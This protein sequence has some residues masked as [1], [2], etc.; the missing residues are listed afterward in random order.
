MILIFSEQQD[1]STN[2]VIDWLHFKDYDFCR[3][4]MDDITNNSNFS[5]DNLLDKKG[6][7][8]KGINIDLISV[9]WFRRW[10]VLEKTYSKL[11]S[12]EPTI[13]E[14]IS[15]ELRIIFGYIFYKLNHAK[16]LTN[17]NQINVNKIVSLDLAHQVG[18]STPLTLITNNTKT[19]LRFKN[20][21]NSIITKSIS[22]NANYICN[23]V[24][25]T[26]YTVVVTDE[27]ICKN[28]ETFFFSIFQENLDKEFEVRT[29]FISGRCFSMAI[30][31]QNDNQ[32]K[33]DFRQYN[34][35][36]PNRT[37]C[38]KHH[39]F[40]EKKISE[41]MQLINLETGSLDFVITKSGETVFLEVNP[42][43]QFGMVSIPCNYYL[44]EEIAN[45][46]ISNLKHKNNIYDR[47][48]KVDSRLGE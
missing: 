10:N 18:L 28:F 11:K 31:S 20:N 23:N 1:I 3:L 32:T 38:Y 37:V 29:F 13:F 15:S 17:L 22:E 34:H 39:E 21:T 46:L 14:S 42:V 8:I 30:F 43:G 16:W 25:Y 2:D 9:V 33:I 19:L 36:K 12:Y 27:D 24:P 7:T 6:F 44:E 26:G 35:E 40:I 45:F 4:N 5:I 41:F 48:R 47:K